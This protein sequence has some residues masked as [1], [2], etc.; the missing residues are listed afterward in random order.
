MNVN[1]LEFK[2][3]NP[4]QTEAA[5][6]ELARDYYAY[7]P[8]SIDGAPLTTM[9]QLAASVKNGSVWYFWWD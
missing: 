1:T 8:D 7:C 2:V 4:P 5:A 3:N 9:G 6:L